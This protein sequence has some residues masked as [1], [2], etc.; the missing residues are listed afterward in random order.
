[1]D[2]HNKSL[3]T[4]K[5]D[6]RVVLNGIFCYSRVLGYSNLAANNSSKVHLFTIYF[7]INGLVFNL[8]NILS[9][10]INVYIKKLRQGP[11]AMFMI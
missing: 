3:E 9:L 10:T 2:L 7:C 6:Y 5:G 4:N 8:N 11:E 1:M